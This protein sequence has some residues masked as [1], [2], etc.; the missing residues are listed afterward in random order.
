MR[1]PAT[2]WIG[3]ILRIEEGPGNVSRIILEDGSCDNNAGEV[4][5]H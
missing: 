1:R 3:Y 2:S 5:P 4:T